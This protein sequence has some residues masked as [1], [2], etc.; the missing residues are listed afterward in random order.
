MNT[1]AD[2]NNLENLQPLEL[3]TSVFNSSVDIPLNIMNSVKDSV[4]D[5]WFY[6]SILAIFLFFNY[7]FYR[8][9]ENFGYDIARTLL[10]SSSFSFLISTSVLL[11]GW[12]NSIYPTIWF[13]SLMFIGFVVVYS[14]KQRNL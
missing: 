3:N 12:I 2:L 9:E 6:A 4:G 14:L 13:G 10:I 8:R 11:S 7:L 1:D 5:V